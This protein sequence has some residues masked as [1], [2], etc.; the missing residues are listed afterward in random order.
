MPFV[1]IE[2]KAPRASRSLFFNHMINKTPPASFRYEDLQPGLSRSFHRTISEADIDTF[3][4]LS[5]DVSPLHSDNAYAAT[6]TEYGRRLV[7]GMHL[8]S[9]VSCLVGMHLPGFRSVCLAQQ[10]DFVKPVY[11]GQ[12]VEVRGEVLHC[13]DAT[14]TVVLATRVLAGGQVCVKGKATVLVLDTEYE[15]KA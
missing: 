12:E 3:G 13:N 9:L 15:K 11:G 8:A 5:G 10:F 14:R 1:K 6:Q 7:H 4:A 2:G